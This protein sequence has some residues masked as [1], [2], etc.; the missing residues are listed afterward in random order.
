MKAAGRSTSDAGARDRGLDPVLGGER[1]EFAR[2]RRLR[3]FA[4]QHETN[5][6]EAALDDQRRRL[7]DL[8]LSARGAEPAGRQHHP[9]VRRDS[10]VVANL[11]DPRATDGARREP[12]EVEAGP[13]DPDP[14]AGCRIHFG[15]ALGRVVDPATTMS[16]SATADSKEVRG[17]VDGPSPGIEV[18][19][20]RLSLRQAPSATQAEARERAWTR[21]TRSA[22]RMRA[23]RRTLN[24]MASGL[25]LEAGNGTCRAPIACA[26]L[27]IS[28]GSETMR[29]RAPASISASATASV[30]RWS[31]LAGVRRRDLH[32]GPSRQGCVHA[33]TEGGKRL[34]RHARLRSGARAR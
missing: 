5:V 1:I 23:S 16:P 2:E 20:A 26:S 33:A 19:S 24:T 27:A 14:L 7:H 8:R 30:A 4:R 21:S 34:G 6:V 9:F 18:I 32:D 17:R 28:P 12:C 22:A 3:R 10:P 13:H 15:R 29:A 11:C 31:P 25:L